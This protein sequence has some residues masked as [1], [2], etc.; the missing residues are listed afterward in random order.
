M[1]PQPL[2]YIKEAPA[3]KGAVDLLSYSMNWELIEIILLLDIFFVNAMYNMNILL[4][5]L[6]ALIIIFTIGVVF[7]LSSYYGFRRKLFPNNSTLH[8]SKYYFTFERKFKSIY[9]FNNGVPYPFVII[10]KS[11]RYKLINRL[12]KTE[13]FRIG[14]DDFDNA[15]I[16][17]TDDQLTIADWIRKPE[18]FGK[19]N[20]ILSLT[21]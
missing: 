5:E 10:R 9:G 6:M 13:T 2:T 15:Y 12:F 14:N 16:V 7:S 19:L 21:P 1:L 3:E 17:L 20:Y 11:W 4:M 8:K 18:I